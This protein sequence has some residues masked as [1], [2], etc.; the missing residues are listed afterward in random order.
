MCRKS[1]IFQKPTF[2][3][4]A[5]IKQVIVGFMKESQTTANNQNTDLKRNLLVWAIYIYIT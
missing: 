2:G 1:K 5:M 4:D 3:C